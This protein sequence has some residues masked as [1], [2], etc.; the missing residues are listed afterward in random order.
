MILTTRK[1][2]LAA[3]QT[4]AYNINPVLKSQR[5]RRKKKFPFLGLNDLHFI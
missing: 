1:Y 2:A 4:I 5:E 3:F